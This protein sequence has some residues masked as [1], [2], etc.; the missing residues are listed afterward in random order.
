MRILNVIC[1]FYESYCQRDILPWYPVP[2]TEYRPNS[3]F[4]LS[5]VQSLG[6]TEECRLKWQVTGAFAIFHFHL[7]NKL[8]GVLLWKCH[9]FL[10]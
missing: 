10:I 5:F 1:I 6:R 2:T 8:M 4:I 7:D 3:F 9:L